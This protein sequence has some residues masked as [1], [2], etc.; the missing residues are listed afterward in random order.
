MVSK[1]RLAASLFNSYE[2]VGLGVVPLNR[3]FFNKSVIYR[4]F[5]VTA[6]YE[7]FNSH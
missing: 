7:N 1:E 4:A 2:G 6:F 3:R 5:G